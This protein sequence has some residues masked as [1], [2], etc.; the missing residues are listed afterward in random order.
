MAI[1]TG[2]R[3][4]MYTH[5]TWLDLEIK[6]KPRIGALEFIFFQAPPTM[7]FIWVYQHLW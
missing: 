4:Y 5:T 1:H 6:F 2:G 3:R 7:V